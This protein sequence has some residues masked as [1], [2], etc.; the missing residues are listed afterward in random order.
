MKIVGD[1]RYGRRH[2]SK[3]NDYYQKFTTRSKISRLR[4]E[5]VCF[6]EDRATCLHN[7]KVQSIRKKKEKN[8]LKN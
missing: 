8:F 6:V 2:A 7:W 4:F 1:R 3:S 5:R